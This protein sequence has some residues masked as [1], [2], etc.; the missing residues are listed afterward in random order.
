M[1]GIQHKVA[2]LTFLAGEYGSANGNLIVYTGA[3]ELVIFFKTTRL[4][5]PKRYFDSNV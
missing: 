3:G 1:N 4:A 2:N 5:F